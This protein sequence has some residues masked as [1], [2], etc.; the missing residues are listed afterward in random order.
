MLTVGISASSY[1][2]VEG[3]RR[4]EDEVVDEAAVDVVGM[5]L[6]VPSIRTAPAT[7]LRRS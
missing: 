6:M 7:E 3:G 2:L 4:P 5:I 1:M